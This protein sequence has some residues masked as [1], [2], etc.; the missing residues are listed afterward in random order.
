MRSWRPFFP[1]WFA[2]L[3]AFRP[4]AEPQPPYG[5]SR[6]IV[7]AVGRGERQGSV[8]ARGVRHATLLEETLEHRKGP[9]FVG[10]L[11]GLAHEDEARDAIGGLGGKSIVH[12]RGGSR[13]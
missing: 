10:G 9:V 13:P 2:G 3:D 4:G 12:C 7:A 8:G 6:E 5:Q 1:G 11:Q